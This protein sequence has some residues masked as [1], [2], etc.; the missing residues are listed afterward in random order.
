MSLHMFVVVIV[1]V[2]FLSALSRVVPDS[3]PMLPYQGPGMS[4]RTMC[5]RICIRVRTGTHR[6][7][8]VYMYISAG[9]LRTRLTIMVTKKKNLAVLQFLYAS[10]FL[11]T[12][13]ILK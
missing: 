8:H 7:L 2:F 10:A 6:H 9:F 12:A 13:V 3:K 1:V 11:V 5:M 4:I